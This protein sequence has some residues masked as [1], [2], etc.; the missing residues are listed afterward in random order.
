MGKGALG[1]CSEYSFR[2]KEISSELCGIADARIVYLEDLLAVRLIPR[3]NVLLVEASTKK[4]LNSA[5]LFLSRL[6]EY[7]LQDQEAVVGGNWQYLYTSICE[8]LEMKGRAVVKEEAIPIFTTVSGSCVQAKSPRQRQYVKSML[9]KAITLCIGPAGVGKTFLSIAIACNLLMTGKR[10]RLIITRPAV[11][12]GESLGFLPGDLEQKIDPY[13]RPLYDALYECLSRE[14]VNDMLYSSQI[15]IAP[16]AYMRGRTLNDAVIVLDEAQNCTI[17]QL[18]MFLTRLGRNSSMCLSGDITQVDL[19]KGKSG[20]ARTAE[21]LE[22]VEHVGIVDFT[23]EDIVRNPIV[24]TIL[25]AFSADRD[26]GK[27]N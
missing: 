11:E 17:D 9:G 18:K 16:L 26:K 20:L 7:Y 6:E 3:G 8:K 15:E 24:G 22:G 27:K 2:Q 21:I 19:A 13:L 14:Q 4:Q 10:K 25:K 5:L 12:A 1:F 23:T